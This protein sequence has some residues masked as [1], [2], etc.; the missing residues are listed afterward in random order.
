MNLLNCYKQFSNIREHS[1]KSNKIDLTNF[2]FLSPTTLLPLILYVEQ[3]SAKEIILPKNENLKSYF[4]TVTSRF[5]CYSENQSFLPVTKLPKDQKEANIIL[6]KIFKRLE[7]IND[8]GGVNTFRYLTSEIVDNIYQHSKFNSAYV[9]FQKYKKY[10]ELTF[11]DDGIGIPGA[12]KNAKV[13]FEDSANALE[14]ALSGVSTKDNQ[15]RGYGLSRNLK[16]VKD[17][18]RGEMLLVSLEGAVYLDQNRLYKYN[19][20]LNYRLKGTLLSYRYNFPVSVEGF[21]EIVE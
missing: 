19:L 10:I 16:L 13:S 2:E 1:D 20:P 4:T 11:Y 12:F 9:M 21:Y 6:S 17:A 3:N 14:L 15:E 8:L 18:L 5:Y 7:P